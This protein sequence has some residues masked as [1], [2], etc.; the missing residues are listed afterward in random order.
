M[1]SATTACQLVSVSVSLL[2]S[3]GIATLSLFDVPELRAQPASRSLPS[4]RW[5]FSR[6]SHIFP[7][8][9]LVSSA[10]FLY[11]AY[12]SLSPGANT[13]EKISHHVS[14]DKKVMGYLAAAALTFGIGP[15]TIL[16]M[17]STNFK[18]IEKNEQGG[19]TRSK[20]EARARN[21]C[22]GGNLQQ[23][24]SHRSAE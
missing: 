14:S 4:V 10:G 9:A 24:Q 3:G 2:A 23:Q 21:Q 5:L 20:G 6:G 17:K 8:A 18:L 1:F 19:G 11:L 16:F 15:F 22:R 13:L 12:A 7:Q